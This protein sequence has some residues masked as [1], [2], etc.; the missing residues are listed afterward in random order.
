MLSIY[1]QTFSNQFSMESDQGK[2]VYL[3]SSRLPTS[4][5]RLSQ[6]HCFSLNIKNFLE[7]YY[8]NLRVVNPQMIHVFKC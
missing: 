8:E 4:T 1:S 3:S 2:F 5:E 7:V 6:N